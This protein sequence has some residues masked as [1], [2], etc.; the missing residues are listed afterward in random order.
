MPPK[1]PTSAN[2]LNVMRHKLNETIGAIGDHESR[3]HIQKVVNAAEQSVTSCA[4]LQEEN[5]ILVVQ[6]HEKKV[7]RSTKAAKV[8][9]TKIMSY[10]DIVQAKAKRDEKAESAT[11]RKKQKRK[12]LAKP[13]DERAKK[14]SY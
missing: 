12:G 1:T 5:R 2:G 8:R 9:T 11:R 4:L 13:L 3:T 14:S 6:N 10:D 7:C